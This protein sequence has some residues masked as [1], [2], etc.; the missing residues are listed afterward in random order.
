M[1]NFEEKSRRS[2]NEIADKYNDSFEGKYTEPFKRLLLESIPLDPGDTVLDIACG[3]GTLLQMLAEKQD[4]AGMGV[5]ISEKMI[6]NARDKMPGMAFAVGKCS[7]V[8]FDDASADI[9]TVSAAYHHFP[10]VTAFAKEAHRLLKPGG[11]VYIAEIYYPAA[12]RLLLNPFVPLLKTGDVKFYS[13]NAIVRTFS[14][15]GFESNGTAVNG[16]I[17][18]ISMRKK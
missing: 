16:H 17:Q 9:L 4:I 7:A 11:R 10:D 8:P 6:A 1:A 2:Y 13:P 15:C 3:N 18:L 12:V 5:D 14:K